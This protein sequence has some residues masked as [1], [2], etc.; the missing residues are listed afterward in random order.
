MRFDLLIAKGTVFDGGGSD[1]FAADVGV[2]GDRVAVIGNIAQAEAGRVINA[3]GMVVCP[4]FVDPH[5]HCHSNVDQ[6]IMHCDNL[7]RQGITTVVAGNCGGSGW[8]VGEHLDKVDR[9]GFKSN[10][11]M[12]VGHHTIRRLAMANSGNIYPDHDQ[13][14]VMQNMVRQGLEEGAFG[15]TVG[16]ARRHEITDEIIQVTHEDAGAMSRRLA[17][18]EGILTG[19]SAGAALHV[20][21]EVAARPENAGKMIVVI[22][23]DTGERYLSTWLFDDKVL[24]G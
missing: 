2:V 23:C 14:T 21:A 3:S 8:P 15:I 5:T 24:G 20:A 17:R 1:G 7:L 9:E 22:L 16:Y 6:D 4:G 12:L 13:I 18:E 10:Y 11:A 19:I